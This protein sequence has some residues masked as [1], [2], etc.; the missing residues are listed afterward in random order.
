MTNLFLSIKPSSTKN[1]DSKNPDF[2]GEEALHT[3]WKNEL[4]SIPQKNTLPIKDK[5]S[6]RMLSEI[7]SQN[8]SETYIAEYISSTVKNRSY[9]K[10]SLYI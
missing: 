8:L 9:S 6:K 5:M 3:L 10:K 2:S 7:L 4:L 1:E